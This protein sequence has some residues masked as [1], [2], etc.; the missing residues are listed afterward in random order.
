MQF[1]INVVILVLL[2]VANLFNGTGLDS[3]YHVT[4]W[5]QRLTLLLFAADVGYKVLTQHQL[6]VEAK[7]FCIFGGMAAI[8][9]ASPWLNGY[10]AADGIGYLWVFC[11]I[12]LLAHMKI[13]EKT[14]LWTGLAYGVMGFAILCIFDFGTTLKGWNENSIAMIG[15]HSYLI[16]LVPFFRTH[17]VRSKLILIASAFLFSYLVSPT[18]SRSGA[19]FGLLA[20]LL[21][22]GVIPRKIVTKSRWITFLWLLSPL[23]IAI[24]VVMISRGGYM[25]DLNMWSYQHFRKPIFNG[26]DE[27]WMMGFRRLRTSP[28]FGRGNFD[29]ANWHNSAITCLTATGIAGYAFW[30]AG[31]A[32]ILNRARGYLHDYIVNGCFVGFIALYAQQSVELGFIAGSPSLLG[33]ILLGIMLG[34]VNY[35]RRRRA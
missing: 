20:A 27:L 5:A 30:I 8:F 26:R 24:V 19:L 9:I 16:M 28:L 17:R 23:F 10:E 35:L 18:N 29:A 11:L 6:R 3:V 7:A 1:I 2:W 33:Y 31:F 14:M 13:D 25:L 34:R 32:N 21:A 12:Y 22:I 15:M 4:E